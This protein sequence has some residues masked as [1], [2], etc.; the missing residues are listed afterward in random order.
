MQT[1]GISGKLADVILAWFQR[2]PAPAD[3]RLPDPKREG[4]G[5]T[6]GEDPGAFP[7]RSG[8]E[9]VQDASGRREEDLG[10]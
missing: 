4:T 6:D 10:Q 2:S 8:E 9:G 7:E 3:P 5:R 1:P